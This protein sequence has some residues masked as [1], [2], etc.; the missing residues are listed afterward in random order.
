MGPR[1]AVLFPRGGLG[2][3]TAQIRATPVVYPV[4]REERLPHRR[5]DVHE[6][7]EDARHRQNSWDRRSNRV[8][9]HLEHL[10]IGKQPGRL[11]PTRD[12]CPARR[13]FA[14][15]FCP[16]K[17][18]RTRETRN[19]RNTGKM[20]LKLT[21]AVPHVHARMHKS[22]HSYVFQT[23]TTNKRQPASIDVSARPPARPA[24]LAGYAR[25]YH[26]LS[27]RAQAVGQA[28]AC[29]P[30][31]NQSTQAAGMA[32]HGLGDAPAAGRISSTIASTTICMR[33][34]RT[35]GSTLRHT[36]P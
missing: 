36:T 26:K 30:T 16:R 2:L 20:P 29:Q 24:R 14:R 22:M 25:T 15:T 11:N 3:R 33:H 5:K 34:R 21:P 4:P 12:S 6:H 35:G 17:R 13:T 27:S 32:V 1:H 9:Q 10:K 31:L 23:L 8:Q 18:R 28:L 7:D 19:T